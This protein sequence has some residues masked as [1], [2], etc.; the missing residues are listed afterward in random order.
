MAPETVQEHLARVLE[1]E[2]VP[3]DA[4]ALRLLSRAARGSMRDALS[5]TDQ[6]IAFGG[7]QLREAPVRQM[8]GSVDRSHVFRLIEALARSDG[9]TVVEI[10]DALRALGL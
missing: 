10:C 5:L 4:Q 3:A 9:R 6:A 1:Q 8:L 2:A 7:G